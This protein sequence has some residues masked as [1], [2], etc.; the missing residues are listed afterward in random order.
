V[1]PGNHSQGIP[2]AWA[3]SSRVRVDARGLAR[4]RGADVYLQPFACGQNAGYILLDPDAAQATVIA[5]MRAQGHDPCVVLQTSPGHL[6]AWIRLSAC[7]L[8]PAQATAASKPETGKVVG[9]RRNLGPLGVVKLQL[10]GMPLAFVV[11]QY[12][13]FSIFLRHEICSNN[14]SDFGLKKG[15]D[16]LA[17]VREKFLAITDRLATF[18]AQCLNVPVEFPLLQRL[19]LPIAVG[20]AKFPGIKIHDTRMIRFREALLHGDTT[21]GG[22]TAKQ[23]QDALLTAF[24]L[25]AARYGLN[26]LMSAQSAHLRRRPGPANER[27]RPTAGGGRGHGRPNRLRDSYRYLLLN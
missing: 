7:P 2:R 4:D 12:E 16:H 26:G 11:K 23:I 10:I 6:Q 5:V 8:D 3:I 25:T 14:L 24:Q 21:A 19:A 20:T 18:Q 13:K 1:A 15:L 22:W 9:Q 27:P 17:A